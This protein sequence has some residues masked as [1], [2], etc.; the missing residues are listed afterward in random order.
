MFATN[1]S[2]Q[3]QETK[4]FADFIVSKSFSPYRFPIEN[5]IENFSFHCL[6]KGQSS[7]GHWACRNPVSCFSWTDAWFLIT[8]TFS[9]FC[10]TFLDRFTIVTNNKSLWKVRISDFVCLVTNLT[11]PRQ[12]AG[13]SL[14]PRSAA[15]SGPCWHSPAHGSGHSHGP[16]PGGWSPRWL[17][18]LCRS[19][20]SGAGPPGKQSGRRR[21]EVTGSHL[22]NAHST[23]GW[24]S[25]RA[26]PAPARGRRVTFQYRRLQAKKKKKVMTCS[27][28]W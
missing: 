8:V 24:T 18:C 13:W 11:R 7:G 27:V 15:L 17:G 1:T 28:Y 6:A 26:H 9:A 2:R 21:A 22:P 16:T 19:A 4:H 3:M 25:H 23:A 5:N 20:R 14:P 12:A 10:T